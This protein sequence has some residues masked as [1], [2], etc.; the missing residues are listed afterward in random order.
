MDLYCAPYQVYG[1]LAINTYEP[2]CEHVI[3]VGFL[4]LKLQINGSISSLSICGLNPLPPKWIDR[5]PSPPF[6]RAVEQVHAGLPSSLPLSPLS[7]SPSTTMSSHEETDVV[8]SGVNVPPDT[9]FDLT[10]R[11]APFM[12]L[13]FM[14]PLIDFL[15]SCELYDEAQLMAAKLALLKPTNMADFAVEI[16]ETLHGTDNVPQEYE[17]RRSE[18]L[19]ALSYAK[20]ECRPMLSLIED[21]EKIMQLQSE[22]LLN[23]NHLEQNEG[24]RGPHA[25]RCRLCRW[26]H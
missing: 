8:S 19:D 26:T 18:I 20:S 5:S 24:V 21:E 23:A 3:D 12:D 25:P 1:R 17:T 7:L 11:L 14:F 22:N 15:S 6:I 4:N 2:N 13:H 9:K 16:H 10:N